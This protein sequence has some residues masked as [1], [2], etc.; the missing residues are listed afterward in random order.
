[1]QIHA[2]CIEL[3]GAGI[4]LRGP[5]GSGKSDLALR[6]ID[7]GA[8]LVA[9][10]R[11]DLTAEDG[12]LYASSPATIA[13]KLEVRGIGIMTLPSVTRTRVGVAVDLVDASSVERLPP[14]QRCAYLGVDLPL[15]AVAPFEASA[16]AKLRAVARALAV[17]RL[18]DSVTT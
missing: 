1:M 8:R 13:G 17:G 6:L 11:T 14:R 18:V 7:G 9:D 4:L 10:D 12:R 15:I 16:P 2:S 5:S 3:S